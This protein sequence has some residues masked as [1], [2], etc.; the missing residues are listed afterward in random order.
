LGLNPRIVADG[1]TV[2][3]TIERRSNGKVAVS[4]VDLV[5]EQNSAI[6]LLLL[7]LLFPVMI[8][9]DLSYFSRL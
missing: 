2:S 6:M 8:S 4:S 5:A 7:L 3:K 9:I 1:F